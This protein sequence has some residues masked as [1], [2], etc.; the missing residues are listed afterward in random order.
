[1]RPNIAFLDRATIPEHVVFKPL[2]SEHTWQNYEMTAPEERVS[3]AQDADIIIT[4]KV[5]MD[6]DT[7]AQLP[8]LKH[9]A[10]IAT[11]YNII[12]IDACK[13]RNISVSNTPDY[14]IT[15]VSEHTLALIFAL[16]RH[17]FAYKRYIA[18]NQ[19]QKSPFFHGYL[20]QT[21]DLKDAQLGIIGSG[22]LGRATAA[23]AQAVGMRVAFAEY[24]QT[25]KENTREGYT[26]FE[27]LIQ[28]SDVISLHCPLN[29]ETRNL[30]AMRE[31]E[32]MQAHAL[33]INTSRG[34][35]VNEHDLAIAIEKQL[36]AGAGLDVAEHEPLRTDS[37]LISI[38]D[39]DNVILTPHIAWSSDSALQRQADIV[40]NN[41]DAFIQGTALNKVV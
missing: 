21:L 26:P 20:S 3:H 27:E 6:A 31:L 41:I 35:I 23:L 32:M 1:M 17:L 25:P 39:R 40:I 37:P 4:N 24:K 8:K 14:S 2:N 12:D 11:G 13:A 7:L 19:W 33:L 22:S 29:D 30:I 38:K 15:S 34:G 10:V 16:R 18:E 36:I 9:I 5:E 28:T